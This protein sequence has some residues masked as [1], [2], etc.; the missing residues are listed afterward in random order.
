[1]RS[2]PRLSPGCHRGAST[3]WAK[4]NDQHHRGAVVWST[5]QTVGCHCLGIWDTIC[6]AR[7]EYLGIAQ[8]CVTR[9]LR[10]EAQ[11]GK[12]RNTGQLLGILSLRM[13]PSV[14]PH[15]C[16]GCLNVGPYPQPE[17]GCSLRAL[18]SMC[19]QLGCREQLLGRL[20]VW[21]RCSLRRAI[22]CTHTYIFS[23]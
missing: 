11:A 6:D 3:P 16:V 22:W 5:S 14:S 23:Y 15:V 8:K 13:V 21:S 9:C 20:R 4:H 17:W 12:G 1:M 19:K 7:E 2:L 18:M 10:E